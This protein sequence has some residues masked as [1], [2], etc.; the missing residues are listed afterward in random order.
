MH[1]SVYFN[2]HHPFQS[3]FCVIM[4]IKNVGGKKCFKTG[5]TKQTDVL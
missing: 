2:Q 3:F 1:Y 5:L 4:K